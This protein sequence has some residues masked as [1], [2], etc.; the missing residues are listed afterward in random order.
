VPR[1]FQ[2]IATSAVS[3]G[4]LR[5]GD[6]QGESVGQG[7][8]TWGWVKD[9]G[10]RIAL[11]RNEPTTIEALDTATLCRTDCTAP[12]CGDRRFDAGEVCDDGNTVDGD[13]CSGDC[14]RVR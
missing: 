6:S 5:R 2:G 3:S 7:I 1:A 11:N 8:T 9:D 12:R 13:G 4:S 10:T 14:R